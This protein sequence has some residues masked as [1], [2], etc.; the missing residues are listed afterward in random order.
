MPIRPLLRPDAGR[1]PALRRPSRRRT[2]A[3]VRR[4]CAVAFAERHAVDRHAAAC[5]VHVGKAVRR[6]FQRRAFIA[7]EQAR[8]DPRVLPDLQRTGVAVRRDD[9]GE[10]AALVVGRDV[11]LLITRLGTLFGRPDPD[12]QEVDRQFRRVVELAV[13]RRCRRSSA[14]RRPARSPNRCPSSPCVPARRRARTTGFP[15]RGAGACR[16]RGPGD[17]VV[18]DHQQ[19]GEADLLRI[20]VVRERNV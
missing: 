15:C 1:T 17:A 8:V 14:A 2:S 19:V 9:E 12:L 5:H 10:L 13:A 4:G 3:P 6:Q 7:V 16:S 18:V 11:R 20:V